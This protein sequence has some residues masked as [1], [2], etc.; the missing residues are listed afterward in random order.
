VAEY[1]HFLGPRQKLGPGKGA[2]FR[3]N[4]LCG[5][6]EKFRWTTATWELLLTTKR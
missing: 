4:P 3:G 1:P 6:A 2:H 5:I